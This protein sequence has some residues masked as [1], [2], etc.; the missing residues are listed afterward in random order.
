MNTLIGK[1]VTL[2][3]VGLVSLRCERYDYGRH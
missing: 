3:M 1:K 2:G